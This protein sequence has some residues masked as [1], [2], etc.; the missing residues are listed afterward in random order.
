MNVYFV[1]P[2]NIKP[3]AWSPFLKY[4]KVK[5]VYSFMSKQEMDARIYEVIEPMLE[6]CYNGQELKSFA[7]NCAFWLR[8]HFEKHIRLVTEDYESFEDLPK[9]EY[10]NYSSSSPFNNIRNL[11]DANC[12]V[13]LNLHTSY[14]YEGAIT[15]PECRFDFLQDSNLPTHI[16]RYCLNI[17]HKKY[18]HTLYQRQSSFVLFNEYFTTVYTFSMRYRSWYTYTLRS[19]SGA[20]VGFMN[21]VLQGVKNIAPNDFPIIE[22]D[23]KRRLTKMCSEEAYVKWQELVIKANEV[24]EE[25]EREQERKESMRAAGEDWRHEVAEM[26]RAFWEECGE[27]PGWD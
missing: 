14:N 8:G 5:R 1:D 9:E 27:G 13:L 21:S 26:N 6:K 2:T 11:D 25:Y 23:G 3:K 18:N 16:T 15:E 4:L 7:D 12:L 20:N 10:K 19:T 22:E 24:A 17:L